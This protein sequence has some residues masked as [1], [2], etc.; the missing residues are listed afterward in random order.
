MKIGIYRSTSTGELI[1]IWTIGG[2][3]ISSKAFPRSAKYS[4]KYYLENQL[5]AS[6]YYD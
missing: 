1:E 2:K 5:N 3:K 4:M 6:F